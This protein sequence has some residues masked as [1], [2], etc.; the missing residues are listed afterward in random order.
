MFIVDKKDLILPKYRKCSFNIGYKEWEYPDSK[1]KNVLNEVHITHNIKSINSIERGKSSGYIYTI[2]VSKIKNKLSLFITEDQNREVIYNGDESLKIIK[3][4]PH[5]IEWTFEYD[6]NNA[7]KHGYGVLNEN[8]TILLE[9][10]KSAKIPSS[11]KLYHLSETNLDGNI[12]HPRVPNNYMTNNGYEENKTPRV[13][14]STSIE[15][16]LIGMSANLKGKTFYVHE[17]ISYNNLKI[18]ENKDILNM[19]PDANLTKET[20]V[21]NPV[22]VKCVSKIKVTDSNDKVL[23]YKY[24][25]KEAETYTWNYILVSYL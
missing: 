10:M 3:V 7:D 11:K 21:L 16:S 12:L 20:W 13:C 24:G 18:K 6:Q 15:G 22:K 17:L 2:D 23:K 1:L 8:G 5:S 14:F 25:D 4:E 19:V 9:T